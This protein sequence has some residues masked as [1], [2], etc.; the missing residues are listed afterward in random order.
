MS[1]NDYPHTRQSYTEVSM[2]TF[3]R[4]LGNM[5]SKNF[6]RIHQANMNKEQLSVYHNWIKTN[7]SASEISP[8]DFEMGKNEYRDVSLHAINGEQVLHILD[9]LEFYT[10]H[11]E[12]I[13][14]PRTA[15]LMKYQSELIHYEIIDSWRHGVKLHEMTWEPFTSDDELALSEFLDAGE[16]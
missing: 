15:K 5:N 9:A 8:I 12:E 14:P 3:E 6:V 11:Y 10:K 16:K 4:I 2:G 13:V 7:L 1:T